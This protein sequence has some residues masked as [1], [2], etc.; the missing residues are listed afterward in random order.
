MT[1]RTP[2]GKRAPYERY[3]TP[4]FCTEALARAVPE[5]RGGTLF[6][7]CCGDTSMAWRLRRRFRQVLLNDLDPRIPVRSHWSL[8]RRGLWE[9]AKP[10]W[11]V[12]NPPFSLTGDVL[13]LALD[14]CTQGI[15]LL[16]R[17]SAMEV[18]EGREFI[19]MYP[20]QRTI[21]LP[22]IRFR[23]GGTDSV[24]VAWFIWARNGLRLSGPPV[25]CVSKRTARRLAWLS[26]PTGLLLP[27]PECAPHAA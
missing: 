4:P 9:M 21:I 19:E 18:C 17:L 23:G 8:S 10:D 14:Y 22:R 15:A 12:T 24:T 20:P 3:D 11:C 2:K 13:N 27:A 6:D 26:S 1:R 25:V 16:L 7:P 5:I